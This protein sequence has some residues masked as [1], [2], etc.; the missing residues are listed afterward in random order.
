MTDAKEKLQKFIKKYYQKEEKNIEQ[1]KQRIKKEKEERQ[2]IDR[3]SYHLFQIQ[4]EI[5]EII[6]KNYTDLALEEKDIILEEPPLFIKSELCFGCFSMAKKLKKAPVLISEEVANFI[7]VSGEKQFIAEAK[8]EGPYVNLNL[9]PEVYGRALNQIIS[10][11]ERY[12]ENNLN[13]GKVILIDYS[14]PNIAKPIGLNHLPSTIIGQVL[15][16]LYYETGASVIRHNYLGDWGTNFGALLWAYFHW[17]DD[18]KIQENPVV[19]LKNL[20]VRFFEEAAQ[21]E[22]MLNEARELFN[23]LE[24]GDEKLLK[25]WKKFR[26]LSIKDF[27]K[28]YKRLGIEFDCYLGESYFLNQTEAVIDEAI[29]K[30]IAKANAE[31]QLVVVDSLVGLPSFLLRKEDGSTL[32]LSRDLAALKVR[33]ELFDLDWLLY[34]VGS[35]QSLHF[36]QLFALAEAMGYLN[37]KRKAKHIPFG[38]ILIE[39]KKMATRKGSLIEM[40]ELI[41]EAIERAKE[42]IVKKDPQINE[43]D[44]KKISEQIGLGAVIY[45]S[46]KQSRLQNINFDW[47]KVLNFEAAS[48]PYLQYSCV[49][50]KSILRRIAQSRDLKIDPDQLMNITFADKTEFEILKKLMLFPAVIINA[51]EEDAPHLLCTYLEELAQLFNRFYDN[52]SVIKTTD[53]NLKNSRVLLIKATLQVLEKGL[54]L[55]NIKVPNKM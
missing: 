23:Q 42:L 38:L 10:L 14:S 50:I 12:G 51:Q 21:N 11:G 29:Q 19:E 41:A 1:I 18:K 22:T 37:A 26:D 52:V 24:N 40:D 46:L 28:V 27:K 8:S 16:N 30:G 47:E 9:K 25:L 32:Y 34:V 33:F 5:K 45:N 54:G 53:E 43:R 6:A 48:A 7:N 17:G 35:E 49:R 55:L 44:I 39:G 2:L 3:A 15:G 4:K 36:Q 20:Y 13:A 31:N